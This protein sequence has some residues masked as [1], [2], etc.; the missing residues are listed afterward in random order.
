MKIFASFARCIVRA[1]TGRD[2][3]IIL[4]HVVPYWLSLAL[5]YTLSKKLYK[6]IFVRT[7]SYFSNCKNIVHKVS[8]EDKLVG[9]IHF[10]SHVIYVNALPYRVK[11]RCSILLQN[12]VVMSLQ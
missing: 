3:I 10:P 9:C 8:K 11:R 5:R 1:F 4:K 12:D 7:L 2:I 6:I